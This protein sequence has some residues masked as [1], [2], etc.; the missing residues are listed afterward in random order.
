MIHYVGISSKYYQLFLVFI[1][2]E[3]EDLLSF[4][5]SSN[6]PIFYEKNQDYD[7]TDF[8]HSHSNSM[9]PSEFH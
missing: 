5:V 8:K 4:T 3:L 1:I 6:D 7:I 9:L 2:I